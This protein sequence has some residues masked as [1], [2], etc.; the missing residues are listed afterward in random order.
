MATMIDVTG[1]TLNP[2]E[3]QNLSE[4]MFERIFEDEN[5]LT[6]VHDIVTG[7]KMKTQIVFADQMGDSL[8]KFSSCTPALAE[9]LKLSQK[10]WDPE[11]I[12]ARWE[13]C[14]N[15]VNQLFKMWKN[16]EKVNPDFFELTS[17]ELAVLVMAIENALP[18]NILTISWFAD[19]Q[20]ALIADSGKFTAGTDLGKYNMIDGLWKQIFA[21][22]TA[23]KVPRTTIAENSLTTTSAQKAITPAKALEYLQSVYGTADTRLT[24]DANG[25]H[26]LVTS[27]IYSAY[28]QYLATTPATAGGNT[29]VI[30]NGKPVV[31][32]YGIEVV[33][34]NVWTRKIQQLFNNGTKLDLPN[35]I[36][37]TSKLNIPIGTVNDSDFDT[38][39]SFYDQYKKIN[40]LDVAM[41]IDAK[42]LQGYLASVAY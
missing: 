30:E 11:L 4:I 34:M 10:Y 6:K 18:T 37:L 2:Q 12:G 39:D 32:F 15:D 31:R 13:H 22:V 1:L 40:V 38:V 9:G 23:G 3:A 27:E 5:L 17:E 33:D 29:E 8:K 24:A 16:F 41:K 14:Q 35:R 28:R 19:K 42:F 25:V 36:V 21:E 20:A 7:I 26:F